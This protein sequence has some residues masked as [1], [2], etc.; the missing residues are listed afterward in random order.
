MINAQFILVF[1]N[2]IITKKLFPYLQGLD[3][4][5]NKNSKFGVKYTTVVQRL[6]VP[7]TSLRIYMNEIGSL[8]IHTRTSHWHN[9]HDSVYI[10]IVYLNETLTISCTPVP[11]AAGTA[12]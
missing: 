8:I 3:C 7:P 2:Q 12:D 4:S 1:Y 5:H 9:E 10:D 6:P 11:A